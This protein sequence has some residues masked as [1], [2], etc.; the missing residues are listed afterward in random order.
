MKKGCGNK[1]DN[2]YVVVDCRIC[3]EFFYIPATPEQQE[4]MD[5]PR[6]E[7]KFMQDIFPELPI[8]DRELLI[9]GTCSTCW[10]KLFSNTLD[11]AQVNALESI[12]EDY[13]YEKGE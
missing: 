4:E 1:M 13:K 10:D 7:R 12:A 11:D 3:Q 5:K 2:Y 8:E 6:A 9:S